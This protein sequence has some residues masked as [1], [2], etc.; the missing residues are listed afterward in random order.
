M[1]ESKDSLISKHME[2]GGSV[3]HLQEL[4][5]NPYSELNKSISHIDTN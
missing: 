4:S 1:I 2:P 5:Q 3:P